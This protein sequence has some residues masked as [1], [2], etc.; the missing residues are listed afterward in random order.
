MASDQFLPTKNFLWQS[1]YREKVR[2]DGKWRVLI[3][4]IVGKGLFCTE[5]C[6]GDMLILTVKKY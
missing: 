1:E 2:L 4:D 3:E 6:M 5:R